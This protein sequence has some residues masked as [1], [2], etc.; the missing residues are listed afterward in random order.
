MSWRCPYCNQIATLLDSNRSE[1]AHRFNRANKDGNLAL[2]TTV[3]VCPNSKCR[4]YTIKAS[5]QNYEERPGRSAV[6]VGDALASWQLKPNSAAKPSPAYI[7]QAVQNDYREACLIVELS[8]KA[9][10]TLSRRCL[11][12]MIRDFHGIKGKTLFAEIQQLEDKIDHTTW[13]AIDSLRSIGNIGAHMEAEINVIV[14]VDPDEASLLIELIET[15]I[16][17]WY[18][19]RHERAQRMSKIIAVAA[20]KKAEK[21]AGVVPVNVPTPLGGK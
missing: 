3:I 5:L 11:Q 9:S 2:G 15:L 4:E 21:N 16:E 13:E 12:G 7:P 18:I 8:P 14:D 20:E 10:A 17:D 19:Q 6:L 1:D